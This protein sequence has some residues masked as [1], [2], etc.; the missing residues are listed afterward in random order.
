MLLLAF[1]AVGVLQLGLGGARLGFSLPG[2][3]I[4]T[5][6]SVAALAFVRRLG[7]PPDRAA[8]VTGIT[9]FGYVAVR[10]WCSPVHWLALPDLYLALGAL[11]AFLLF[12][13]HLTDP[14]ERLAFVVALLGLGA[15]NLV[16]GARQFSV[17]DDFMLFGWL[18]PESYR[19]RASGCFICPNH[20]AGFLNVGGLFS[21]AAAVWARVGAWARVGFGYGALMCLAG[22]LLT[23]SRG[24]VLSFGA[25]L[26][27]VLWLTFRR[28]REATEA[29]LLRPALIAVGLMAVVAAGAIGLAAQSRGLRQRADIFLDQGDIRL[30]LWPAAVEQAKLAPVLGT[31]AGTYLYYG[32][33]FR[34]PGI[35]LDPVYVHND[36]LHLLAEYG[37]VG[38]LAGAL[39]LGLHVRAGTRGF[40]R[41]NLRRRGDGSRWP[42]STS[43]AINAG[44]LA[45]A[46]ALAVHS[47]FDFNLHL[48]ANGVLLAMVAGMLAQPGVDLRAAGGPPRRM[49]MLRLLGTLSAL[50]LA[51]LALPR[52]PGE[53]LAEEARVALRDGDVLSA[54][55][56]AR[57][58]LEE[59]DQNPV[60][61]FYLGEA[62][63]RMAEQTPA[64]LEAARSFAF[65]AAEA[66]RSA[67][68]LFP[69]DSRT[70]VALAW[71]WSATGRIEDADATFAEALEIDPNHAALHLIFGH[72]LRRNG[73]RR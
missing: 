63:R 50:A 23:G 70:L 2:Y 18:R 15:F 60:L 56:L 73:R 5:L 64:G 10:A 41:L 65:G 72:H 53:K 14:R 54:S 21:L 13:C 48:P 27:V 36:Y 43:L 34:Q 42:A 62:R 11:A 40:A 32:R 58:A 25:G 67:L 39:F 61:W 8:I 30:R 38:L 35:E 26:A 71:I 3:G 59:E 12:A 57:L 52:W 20:L 33:Q 17:G 44:A 1:A 47:V 7:P 31:G 49:L 9:F 28:L 22:L 16:I 55:R 24:G 4:L 69:R 45:S 46:A 66:Y 29:S 68:F 19:G 51:A 37:G 6:A